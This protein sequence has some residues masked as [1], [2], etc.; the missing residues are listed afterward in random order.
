MMVLFVFF[1]DEK[2]ASIMYYNKNIMKTINILSITILLFF[3]FSCNQSANQEKPD[4]N[5]VEFEKEK[6]SKIDNS[7]KRIDIKF[8]D[9][10]IETPY[11]ITCD[12]FESFFQDEIDSVSI[13]DDK[14]I[15]EFISEIGKLNKAD[16]S[17]YSL[18]DTRIKISIIYNDSISEMCLDRFV[19]SNQKD[20]YVLSETFE[21]LLREYTVIK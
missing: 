21:K 2:F 7:I 8:V 1:V 20:L 16:L 9:I 17:K 13:S 19:L 5:V 3:V 10:E 12:N 6:Q 15:S 11:R 18:P 4:L 14:N